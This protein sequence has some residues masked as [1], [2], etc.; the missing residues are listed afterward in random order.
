VRDG[1]IDVGPEALFVGPSACQKVCGRSATNKTEQGMAAM[2]RE[3][4]GWGKAALIGAALVVTQAAAELAMGRPPICT[5]G[6]VRLWY[7]DLFGPGLSQHI[8]DWYSFTHISHG[9]VFYGLTK[10]VAPRAPLWTRLAATLALEVGWEVAE[11]SPIIIDRY[12][13]SALAQGYVGDSVLNSVSDTLFCV[14]GFWLAWRLPVR[15]SVA[16]VVASELAL[17]VLIH[18]NLTL[19][20]L[21]L[22][23]P[24]ESVSRWQ[25]SGG[26]VGSGRVF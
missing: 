19:N 14:L 7:G 22:A 18:D 2:A 17:A 20:V 16:M 15:A 6:Y 23:H 21:Q 10:L 26:W 3:V 9:L 24:T 13:Q 5:C 4:P 1:R 25:A 11:N 8:A 12:R